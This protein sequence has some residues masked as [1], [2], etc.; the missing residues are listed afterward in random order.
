MSQIVAKPRSGLGQTLDPETLCLPFTWVAGSQVFGKSSASFLGVLSGSCIRSRVAGTLHCTPI[1]H[2]SI[3]NKSMIH[4]AAMPAPLFKVL[5][6]FQHEDF[7]TMSVYFFLFL[8]YHLHI[9][10]IY[11]LI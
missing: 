3:I 8:L 5:M 1:L 9:Y 7:I 11:F 2:V 10:S 6:S 4:C